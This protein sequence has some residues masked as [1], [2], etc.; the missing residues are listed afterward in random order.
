MD[1][2]YVNQSW[3]M[4]DSSTFQNYSAGYNNT[5]GYFTAGYGYDSP[6][7]TDNLCIGNTTEPSQCYNSVILPVYDMRFNEWYQYVQLPNINGVFG[8]A[9]FPNYLDMN[10]FWFNMISQHYNTTMAVSLTPTETDYS[11]IPD[12]ANA[13]NT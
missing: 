1:P 7:G 12:A 10:S 13:E 11:W 6:L 3:V 8:M 5:R 2:Y 9:Y 4:N